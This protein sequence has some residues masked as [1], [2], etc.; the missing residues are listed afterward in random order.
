MIK[1]LTFRILRWRLKNTLPKISSRY[2]NKLFSLTYKI[3]IYLKP[4]QLWV[5]ILALLNKKDFKTF[6]SIPS[7]FIL[8]SSI[9]SDSESEFLFNDKFDKNILWAKL[10]ANK[11]TDS[12]NNW[13]SFF[14]IL[15]VLALTTRI[16][17]LVFKTLW[18]PFKI[19]FIYYLLK[20]LGFDFS[21]VFNALNTLSLGIVEWFYTKITNFVELIINNKK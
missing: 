17:K 11:F 6:L 9:F 8:F 10:D 16:I 5:L 19:A 2:F 14:W 7:M 3:F 18:I 21:N 4:S 20:Y 12:D 13:E 1:F 15:I